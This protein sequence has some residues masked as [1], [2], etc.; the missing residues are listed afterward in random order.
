MHFATTVFNLLSM[1]PAGL[2]RLAIL[3]EFKRYKADD[4]NRAITDLVS[5][6]RI[7][8]VSGA[9]DDAVFK[10]TNFVTKSDQTIIDQVNN[11]I[12]EPIKASEPKPDVPS[13]Q[14]EEAKSVRGD[15][16]PGSVTGRVAWVLFSTTNRLGAAQISEILGDVIQ[17]HVNVA[18]RRLMDNQYIFK[19]KV[20][21]GDPRVTYEWNYQW[22]HPFAKDSDVD[23]IPPNVVPVIKTKP[24]GEVPVFLEETDAKIE[25]RTAGSKGLVMA[26]PCTRCK[27]NKLFANKVEA[28]AN[29]PVEEPV[30]VGVDWG[31]GDE[32]VEVTYSQLKAGV[33]I[34]SIKPLTDNA[35][36]SYKARL[37]YDI[38]QRIRLI[39]AE[40]DLHAAIF[41]RTGTLEDRL[42]ALKFDHQHEAW[43]SFLREL[44]R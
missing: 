30:V 21:K 35:L 33:K 42:L 23:L 10:V 37:V 29:E 5:V 24:A 7:V 18:L 2:S 1:Q 15:I 8:K 39:K 11:L 22:T 40:L 41:V 34:Q 9:G 19:F 31:A 14:A 26:C 38:E 17:N 25:Y 16:R 32:S 6:N 28:E 43:K 27:E 44:N 36:E 3:N 20:P 13:G 4:I 12:K